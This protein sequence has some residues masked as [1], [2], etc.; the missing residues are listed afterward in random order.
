[1]RSWRRI[2]GALICAMSGLALPAS[3]QTHL[4]HTSTGLGHERL[5]STAHHPHNSLYMVSG[6]G[7]NVNPSAHHGQTINSSSVM[8]MWD[9]EIGH[10]F[11]I[12]TLYEHAMG[13]H[14]GDALA[15]MLSYHLGKHV[16]LGT[17]PGIGTSGASWHTEAGLDWSWMDWHIGPTVEWMMLPEQTSM[18]FTGVHIGHAIGE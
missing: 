5:H 18:I 2:G 13:D 10:H 6:I 11:G 3:G 9:H 12:E 4:H 15:V 1:M 8:L 7:M 14:T 17:G 16:I